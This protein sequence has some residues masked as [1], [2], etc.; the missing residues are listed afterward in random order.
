MRSLVATS[1]PPRTVIVGLP[2]PLPLPSRRKTKVKTRQPNDTGST[3]W[4]I[5]SPPSFEYAP[6]YRVLLHY[7]LWN[8]REDIARLVKFAVPM[9]SMNDSLRIVTMA[10]AYDTSI[11]VT[12]KKEEAELYMQRLLIAGL[13]SS[14]EEA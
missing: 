13:K 2:L 3:S 14:T 5:A 9:L 8:D 12:V 7:S 1:V 4:E 11:V 6:F 10:E